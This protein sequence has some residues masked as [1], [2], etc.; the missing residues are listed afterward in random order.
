MTNTNCKE[1]DSMYLYKSLKDIL[2]DIHDEI[3][4][5][6]NNPEQNYLASSSNLNQAKYKLFS[7]AQEFHIKEDYDFN[8]LDDVFTINPA[9]DPVIPRNKTGVLSALCLINKELVGEDILTLAHHYQYLI[10]INKVIANINQIRTDY[11]FGKILHQAKLYQNDKVTINN[12]K[13]ILKT[14]NKW[15]KEFK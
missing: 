6:L 3:S 4:F 1:S 11:V 2:L 5:C 7:K 10:D 14:T 12:L 9:L 8:K 15:L 13:T